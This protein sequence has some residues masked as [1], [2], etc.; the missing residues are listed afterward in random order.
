MADH[1]TRSKTRLKT[2]ARRVRPIKISSEDE[3]KEASVE[4]VV[5]KAPMLK[6][7]L[8]LG[9]FVKW[10]SGKWV[11][12]AERM[13]RCLVY[14][15]IL[16]SEEHT[17]WISMYVGKYTCHVFETMEIDY[18][19]IHG[20][21]NV[22]MD[23]SECQQRNRRPTECFICFKEVCLCSTK[24]KNSTLKDLVL[25]ER[26]KIFECLLTSFSVETQRLMITEFWDTIF[27]TLA[28]EH[29]TQSQL[30]HLWWQ[31]KRHGLFF[32]KHIYNPG[33]PEA[34]KIIF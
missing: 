21:Q 14:P 32:L 28:S 9:D 13:F 26:Q 30:L 16:A 12:D 10:N 8:Y 20:F 2:E 34:C 22:C 29:L 25:Q 31:S 18:G 17:K 7:P 3:Q 15:H 23:H 5:P 24:I 1:L 11:M 19:A 33:A 6:V 4:S 27:R